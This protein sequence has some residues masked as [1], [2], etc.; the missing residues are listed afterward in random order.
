MK[1][2]DRAVAPKVEM[3]KNISFPYPEMKSMNGID[4]YVFDLGTQAYS[5]V[6]FIFPAG[7]IHTD[8]KLIADLTADM[9]LSG[10]AKHNSYEIA[11]NLDFY[12][13]SVE[14]YC[15]EDETTI[16][17]Y[18]LSKY[19]EEV[20]VL[21]KE[22]FFGSVFP[23]DEARIILNK[24]KQKQQINFQKTSYMAARAFRQVM[25]GD[26]H[27]YGTITNQEDYDNVKMSDVRA[28]H[29]QH[30][31]KAKYKIVASGCLPSNAEELLTL[32]T[33]DGQE[34]RANIVTADLP[35]DPD[36]KK[37]HW[38]KVA[39]T[40]QS[41]IILGRETFSM[42]H[43]DYMDMYVLNSLLGGYFGSRLMT[44]LREDKGYTYGINSTLYTRMHTG[45]FEISAEVNKE[46]LEAAIHEI[47]N[48]ILRLRNE[49]VSEDEL[50]IVKNYIIGHTLRGID[51][52]VKT[53]KLFKT[54]LVQDL[55]FNFSKEFEKSI[56]NVKSQKLMDPFQHSGIRSLEFT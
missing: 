3:I 27:P 1:K 6:Q 55:D 16:R 14:P 26:R 30:Y 9:L 35:S 47:K 53:A 44:N 31:V 12:G 54:L 33:N 24:W 40:V 41:S 45:V 10:T 38:I 21:V 22:L 42:H 2:P 32:F 8:K 51:G 15:G 50:Q 37:E 13:A 36:S 49:P 43:P 5:F 39:N 23:D 52:P 48:E 17:I 28:F 19:L 20:L 46:N 56:H 7:K 34:E 25:F 29:I 11:E 18:C 4:T